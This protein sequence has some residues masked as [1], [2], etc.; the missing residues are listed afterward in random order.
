M[1][2]IMKLDKSD[3]TEVTLSA[4][5]NLLKLKG[6]DLNK[7]YADYETKIVDS[8]LTGANPHYKIASAE[9]LKE[10]IEEANNNPT[11]D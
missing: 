1:D 4:L 2:D 9:L 10:L 6:H 11:L 8:V 7:I 5:I 3:V